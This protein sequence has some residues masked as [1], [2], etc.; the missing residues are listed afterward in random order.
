MNNT[1]EEID[2]QIESLYAEREKLKAEQRE[3]E[4]LEKKKAAEERDK[5][6]LDVMNTIKKFNE[7]HNEH[8]TLATNV[9]SKIGKSLY[10]IFFPWI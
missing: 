4:E 8:I 2:K 6:L 9:D 1:I 3:K 10:D 5:D 7:K